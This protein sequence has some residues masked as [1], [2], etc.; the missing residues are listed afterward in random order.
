MC[1]EITAGGFHRVIGI[2]TNADHSLEQR[3][4]RRIELTKYRVLNGNNLINVHKYKY[5]L[6]I[7]CFLLDF[8]LIL[9]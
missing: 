4:L 8:S 9:H 7:Q 1:K 2:F 5:I 3:K 6:T